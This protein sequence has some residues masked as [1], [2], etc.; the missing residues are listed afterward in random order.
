MSGDGKCNGEAVLRRTMER[1][2]RAGAGVIDFFAGGDF[3]VGFDVGLV[4]RY[5]AKIRLKIGRVFSEIVPK[6]GDFGLFVAAEDRRGFRRAS[7]DF[8]KMFIEGVYGAVGTRM[9]K[10]DIRHEHRCVDRHGA[11]S[12]A[13]RASHT[14][15][16]D[17]CGKRRFDISKPSLV[18]AQR[19]GLKRLSSMLSVRYDASG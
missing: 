4:S 11:E 8:V 14:T 10:R 7:G 13:E 9:G 3:V 16:L 15:M 19:P 12:N 2:Q 6:P 5:S 17:R 1:V 18:R